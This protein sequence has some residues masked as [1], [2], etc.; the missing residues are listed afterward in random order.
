MRN[1][2]VYQITQALER[3]ARPLLAPFQRFLPSFGGMDFSPIVYII[4]VEGVQRFLI[5]PMFDGL[6]GLFGGAYT[7]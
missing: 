6:R 4:I 3:V 5:P 1:R 7:V 2:A